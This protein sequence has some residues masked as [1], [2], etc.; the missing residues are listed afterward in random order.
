MGINTVRGRRRDQARFLLE[1][2]QQSEARQSEADEKEESA[3]AKRSG[4]KK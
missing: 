4:G 1:L 3:P 2:A